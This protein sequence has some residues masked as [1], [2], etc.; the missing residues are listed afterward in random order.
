[1]DMGVDRNINRAISELRQMALD[2]NVDIEDLLRKAYLLSVLTKQKDVE[3]W[4]LDEQNGYKST[5]N[6]PN[7]RYLRGEIKALNNIGRWVPMHFN[8]QEQAEW[9]S[10]L[11][12]TSDHGNC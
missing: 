12:F 5:D 10:K 7:Y 3:K 11:P 4:I 2:K 9:F 8:K 1:M 6:L